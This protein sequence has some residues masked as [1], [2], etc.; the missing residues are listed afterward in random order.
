MTAPAPHPV[1]ET[2]RLV[3]RRP[4]AGDEAAWISFALSDRSCF[5]RDD[6][7]DETRAW[8]QLAGISGHWDL[9]GY[10]VFVFAL[11]AAPD[12]ALGGA[13]PWRPHG[14]P[15]AELGWTVWDEA[16]EGRGYAHEAAVAARAY[17]YETL[18]WTTAVSYID[19]RNLRSIRLA[20]RMGATPDWTAATPHGDPL[21]VFRHPGPAALSP[22]ATEDAR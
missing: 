21:L 14:W 20:E 5:V 11:R 19:P 17:A 16:A 12:A 6:E 4:Q 1:I 7:V 22:T 18:G 9:R 8:R 3:L 2:D 10:G 13:G 15:E